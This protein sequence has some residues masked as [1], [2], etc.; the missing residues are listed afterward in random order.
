[1]S[2]TGVANGTVVD[3]LIVAELIDVCDFLREWLVADDVACSSYDRHVG[4]VGAAIDL[5]ADLIRLAAVLLA[6]PAGTIT[7]EKQ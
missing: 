6:S 3:T 5:H 4:Q 7:E 1:M 2:A